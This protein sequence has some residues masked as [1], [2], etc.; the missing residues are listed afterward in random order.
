MAEEQ[1]GQFGLQRIYVKDLSFESP[2]APQSFLGEWKPEINL[3]L[4]SN[5]EKIDDENNAYEIVL[6]ITLTVK[7]NDSVA[8]L[9]EVQQAGLFAISGVEGDQLE[10][11]LGSYCPNILFP[12]GREVVSDIVARGSFPQLLLTPVNFDALY[13]E[14]KKRQEEAAAD[15]TRQ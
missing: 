2:G 6:T 10:H 15:A 9:I 1:E 7:N 5:A 4:N 12:Y 8:Y 3:Q 13:M 11:L 14:A